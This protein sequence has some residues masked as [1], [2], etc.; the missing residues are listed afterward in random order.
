MA[1]V[2]ANGDTRQR[3]SF[4][5]AHDG[6]HIAY[7][8]HGSGPPLV[9]AAC[10]LSH[11]QFD[12]ESPV[13]RHFLADLGNV[14]TVIRYDER[15]F[16]LSDR[17]VYDHSLEARLSDLEAVVEHAGI[18]R[19]ALMGMSQ[20]G[21]VTISYAHRHPERVTRLIFYGSF[22]G[23]LHNATAEELEMQEAFEQ[24]IKVGWA[25]PDSEFRR[26]FTSLMIPD[27]TP[28]QMTWLDELQRVSTS[29]EI[30]VLS[31]RQRAKANAVDLLSELDAPTLVL[32]ARGDRMNNFADGRFLASAIDGARLVALE[33]KNHIVLG[34]EPAWPVFVD[35]VTRFLEPDRQATAARPVD[36]ASQLSSRELDVLKLAAQGRTNEEIA[37]ELF[38]SRAHGRT[39]PAEHVRQARRQRQV[40]AHGGG[41]RAPRRNRLRHG[42]PAPDYALAAERGRRASSRC[43]VP[44][45]RHP[46]RFLHRGDTA[47][48]ASPTHRHPH[49]DKGIIMTITEA[50]PAVAAEREPTLL[51]RAAA[52]GPT[53]AE[54]AARYDQQGTWVH[55]SFEHIRDAGL[56]AIAVPAE[57]GG[58]GA[59]IREVALVQRELAKHCGSTALASAMHQHVTAFTAWRYGR[60]LP[61][62]EA[63]LRR[64]AED[65]IVLVSTGGGDYTHPSGTAVRVEEDG[66]L[67]NGRKSFV[68]Q[69]PAGTVLSTM[70]T[71]DDPARG[72]RVLNM[73]VPFASDGV[74]IEERWNTLGM[75]G[76]A[77]NDV[78]FDDVF[79]PDERVLADRPHGELD[80]PL[81]VISSIGFTIIS[82]VYLGLAEGAFEHA[83]ASLAGK[84]HSTV[85][86]RRVGLMAHRLRIADWALQG[87]FAAVGDS[88]TPSMET[89]AAVMAAK[90]E[91]VLTAIEVC[92]VAMEVGGRRAFDRDSPIERAYRDVRAGKFH[93]FDPE[94][95]LVH[96][97]RLALGMSTD[98]PDEW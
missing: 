54:H 52:C 92:D 64:V 20:G 40:G 43:V 50:P 61:G 9:I 79:V 31:R 23:A 98:R 75:R 95:T 6:V 2:D 59:T 35:E 5:T 42:R 84:P 34:D 47:R 12:W 87:A 58:D 7:A 22:A 57:L 80:G 51:E 16:G 88:P 38:V 85:T 32:H 41:R 76:T 94:L 91:I 60:G 44:L 78:T 53:L 17:E 86:Q 19:F 71:F 69:S 28:E 65:G 36:V 96:G 82:A 72:Y 77:S 13:W 45:M 30:A 10:W 49:T 24:M 66:Y 83:V 1:N 21:P 27:A 46:R 93:P 73:S 48:S 3:V 62:A 8:V 68:S 97:G 67:V 70:F 25:R 4:C 33:S 89:V 90:R 18:D 11:L 63:T 56:L 29:T 74:R 55:E 26:V 81:Q 39:P 37:N 15:G 14:A